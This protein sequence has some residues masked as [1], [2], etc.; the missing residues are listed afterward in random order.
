MLPSYHEKAEEERDKINGLIAQ[1]LGKPKEEI[2]TTDWERADISSKIGSLVGVGLETGIIPIEVGRARTNWYNPKRNVL[3]ISKEDSGKDR[4]TT[5]LPLT[6]ETG[7]RLSKWIQERRHLE[8]YDGTDRL[9]LN[10]EGNPYDSKNLCYLVRRLC[11]EAGIPHENR[12]IVWYSLRHNLGQSIEETE[13]IS[14][15]SDQLRHDSI[16]T[17]K[18]TY[19][20]S[21]IE[22]RR[23]TLEQINQVAERTVEDPDF[24]PYAGSDQG[25]SQQP[26]EESARSGPTGYTQ[27]HINVHIEDTQDERVDLAQKILSDDI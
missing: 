21:T 1:R 9:W 7:E 27:K 15:A 4:P 14:Q 3:K 23:H 16:Q 6:E 10:R 26:K 24:N 22:S 13:D 2:T 20:E 25:S 5:E 11:E 18:E 12:K 19:G 17:T 8:K